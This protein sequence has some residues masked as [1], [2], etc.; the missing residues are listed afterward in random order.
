MVQVHKVS[1]A[2]VLFIVTGVVFLQCSTM[3]QMVN[4]LY[5]G[6]DFSDRYLL[7]YP[8]PLKK[9]RVN[10]SQDIVSLYPKAASQQPELVIH[11]VFYEVLQQYLR[12]HAKGI[13]A[14]G[15]GAKRNALSPLY[16]TDKARKI[17]LEY[18]K[19]RI[20][21]FQIATTNFLAKNAITADCILYINRAEFGRLLQQR[22]EPNTTGQEVYVSLMLQYVIWDHPENAAI[23]YGEIE[24]T[25]LVVQ[26]ITQ[27]TWYT[28]FDKASK[29]ILDKTPFR[30]H[31]K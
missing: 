13:Q 25:E 20:G 3:R 24:V 5:K 1:L 8:A 19:K 6:A 31:H 18:D 27:K 28:L 12:E 30:R 16:D 9:I 21:D 26:D 4:P 22:T 17:T 29:T 14:A 23:A 7:V 15:L 10:N 11:D 2:V